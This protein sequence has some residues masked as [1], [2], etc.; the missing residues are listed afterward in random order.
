MSRVF[1]TADTHFGHGNIIKYCNRP[2]LTDRD[3]QALA[4]NGGTWH[5]GNWKGSQSSVW[6]MTRE[7]I[8]MMNATFIDNIN[9]HVGPDDTL[10]HLGDWAFAPRDQYYNISRGY[11]DRITCRHIRFVWGNHDHRSIANLFEE[12]HHQ[13]EVRVGDQ[14]IFLNHYAMAIWNQSHRKSI[15]LYGHSHSTAEAWLNRV[16]PGRRSLDVGVD[17]ANKLLGEYR[18]FVLEEIMSIM[19]NRCGHNIGDHH[20]DPNSQP[21]E[22]Y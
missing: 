4:D 15:H 18:P 1:F 12:S 20:I 8:E 19:V 21:E 3:R 16:M 14:R 7:A 17:N 9:A 2:F 6:K 13:T 11:R 22:E 10:W 5:D